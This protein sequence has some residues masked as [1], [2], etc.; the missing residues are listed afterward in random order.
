M[1]IVNLSAD[2]CRKAV[3]PE[4]KKKITFWDSSIKGFILEV[5]SSGNKTY[6][7]R[8]RLG[9]T[10][11]QYKIG[12]YGDLTF[13]RARKAAEKARGKVV[14]NQD[15][16]EE[17]RVK[18]KS[19]PCPISSSSTTYPSSRRTK[20]HGPLTPHTFAAISYQSSANTTWTR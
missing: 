9:T 17:K 20:N 10:Q 1:P 13:D 12:N 18:R 8:Y 14:L 4:G 2:F 19:L 6:G 11:N 16:A 3:C 5:R 7:L 15:P